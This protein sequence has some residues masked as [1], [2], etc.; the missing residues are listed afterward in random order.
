MR[1]R[2]S[3]RFDPAAVELAD[4]HYS[5]QQPGTPQFVPPGRN[6]VFVAGDPVAALWVSLDQRF[7][8]HAWAGAWTC[9]LFRNEGAGLS[10]DLIREALAA[11]RRAWGE[12]PDEGLVTFVNPQAVRSSN[13]GFCFLEAGFERVGVTQKRR[14]LAL[15]I[16]PDNFPDPEAPLGWNF[17]LAL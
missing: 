7:A 10:S 15:R 16:E 12:P 8:S 5:R 2:V 3:N 1:W 11:T 6:L 4:R 9:P 13:P 14:Y 17:R